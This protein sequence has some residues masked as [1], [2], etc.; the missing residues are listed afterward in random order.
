MR[1]RVERTRKHKTVGIDSVVAEKERTPAEDA[2]Q[3][4]LV[5]DVIYPQIEVY[6][7]ASLPR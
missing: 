6:D 3:L 2:Y 1:T 5:R 4:V 7:D